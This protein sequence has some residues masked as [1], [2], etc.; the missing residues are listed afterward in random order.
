MTHA[1]GPLAVGE[2]ELLEDFGR[3]T[4]THTFFDMFSN[5][6]AEAGGVRE[7]LLGTEEHIHETVR[8]SSGRPRLRSCTSARS[9]RRT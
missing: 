3:Y 8:G 5:Y 7:F 9:A 6:Y 2:D 1:A 4:S